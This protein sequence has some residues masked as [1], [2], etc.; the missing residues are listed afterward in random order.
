M[1]THLAPLSIQIKRGT[2]RSQDRETLLLIFIIN[3]IPRERLK[4]QWRQNSVLDSEAKPDLQTQ[5]TF[6]LVLPLFPLVSPKF[7]MPLKPQTTIWKPEFMI[8]RQKW[9]F[10]VPFVI[11]SSLSDLESLEL[12]SSL[13][14][15]S[16][17]FSKQENMP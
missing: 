8:Q 7:L 13:L 6:P 17:T 16:G 14:V 5:T 9:V 1:G 4:R 2:R 11:S 3:Q 10:Q 12:F 15:T